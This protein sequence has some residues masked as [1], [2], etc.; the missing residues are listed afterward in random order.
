M[1]HFEAG[2]G[3]RLRRQARTARASWGLPV[4]RT[5][6]YPDGLSRKHR[7]LLPIDFPHRA[8]AT[9]TL[10]LCLPRMRLSSPAP[11]TPCGC[12]RCR[13]RTTIRRLNAVT[14]R[15]SHSTRE[16]EPG[17]TV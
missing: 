6:A 8:I 5:S 15:R 9:S 10:W 2:Q 14:G 4:V 7:I 11:L 13:S 16:C 12:E 3:A 1:R 17:W